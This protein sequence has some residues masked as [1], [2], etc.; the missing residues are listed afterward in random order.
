MTEQ[1]ETNKGLI[2]LCMENLF[3]S[4]NL[5]IIILF[6]Y[7]LTYIFGVLI[8]EDNRK[9]GSITPFNQ[10]FSGATDDLMSSVLNSIDEKNTNLQKQIKEV[11][12]LNLMRDRL[13]ERN[14]KVTDL[15]KRN[16]ATNTNSVYTNFDNQINALYSIKSNLKNIFN[17]STILLTTIGRNMKLSMYLLSSFIET[18]NKPIHSIR[19]VPGINPPLIPNSIKR[20]T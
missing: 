1:L 14:L 4:S 7:L 20:Y 13:S 16:I 19:K 12:E 3:D 18:L 6:L 9:G 2:R 5:I 10:L 8:L 11:E 15:T 17:V